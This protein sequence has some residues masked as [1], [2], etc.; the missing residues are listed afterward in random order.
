MYK[1]NVKLHSRQDVNFSET[2]PTDKAP[3]NQRFNRILPII[4]GNKILQGCGIS[5]LLTH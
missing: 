5:C 1:R 3:Y 2:Q 4:I